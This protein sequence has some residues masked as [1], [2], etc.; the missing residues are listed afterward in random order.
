MKKITL[1]KVRDTLKNLAPRIEL[2]PDIMRNAVKPIEAMM[3][4]G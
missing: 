1:E 2:A 4:L 3:K